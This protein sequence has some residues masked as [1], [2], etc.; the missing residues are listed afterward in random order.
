MPLALEDWEK[1]VPKLGFIP[2]MVL[3]PLD[4]CL[5]I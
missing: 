2:E 5:Q 4:F 3:L 1:G